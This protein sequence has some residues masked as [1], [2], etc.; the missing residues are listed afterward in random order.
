MKGKVIYF[1]AIASLLFGCANEKPQPPIIGTY[2]SL[3]AQEVTETRTFT[4]VN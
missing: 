2:A 4:H 3:T 1:I